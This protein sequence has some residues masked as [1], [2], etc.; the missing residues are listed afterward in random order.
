MAFQFCRFPSFASKLD[1]SPLNVVFWE[2]SKDHLGV[3]KGQKVNLAFK[4]QRL[5][6]SLQDKEDL[7]KPQSASSHRL[8]SNWT[9]MTIK[10]GKKC[11][12]DK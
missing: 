5:T 7:T 4:I 1:I 12:D 8:A 9:Q 2:C 11:Q 10:Q 3:R 6:K